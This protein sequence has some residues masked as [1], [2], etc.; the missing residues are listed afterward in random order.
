MKTL[1]AKEIASSFSSHS[2]WLGL[3]LTGLFLDSEN[4]L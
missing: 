1:Q 3:E 2:F 4:M